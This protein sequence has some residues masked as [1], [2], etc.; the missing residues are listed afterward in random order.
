MEQ[1][2]RETKWGP[3]TLGKQLKL[4]NKASDIIVRCREGLEKAGPK[5]KATYEMAR[6]IQHLE[7]DRRALQGALPLFQLLQG[8]EHGHN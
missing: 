3:E 6:N 8:G 2:R 4:I 7:R 1:N 5:K